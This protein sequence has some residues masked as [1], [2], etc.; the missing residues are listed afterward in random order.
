MTLLILSLRGLIAN[1]DASFQPQQPSLLLCIEPFD[2]QMLFR[3]LGF[4]AD[5]GPPIGFPE[6]TRCPPALPH[7]PPEQ[8]SLPRRPPHSWGRRRCLC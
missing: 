2:L 6:A 4:P 3:K 1:N 8:G 5:T 7:M